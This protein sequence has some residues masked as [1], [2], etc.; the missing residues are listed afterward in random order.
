MN[1][2]EIFNRAEIRKIEF[3]G[4]WY[5]RLSD[6]KDILNEDLSEVKTIVLPFMIDG[7]R[8]NTEC[9][10]YES[11]KNGRKKTDFDKKIIQAL[12]FK[13]ERKK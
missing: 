4:E 6:L 12:N 1:K 3:D 11:I 13:P 10:D 2:E 8:I 5:F 9:A 7:E